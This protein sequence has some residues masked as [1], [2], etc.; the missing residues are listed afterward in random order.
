[1]LAQH[2]KLPA[3]IAD[4]F[5]IIFAEVR[6]RLEVRRQALRQP[7]QLDITLRFALEPTAGLDAVEVAINVK[8][9]KDGGMVSRLARLCWLLPRKAQEGKVKFV[10]EYIDH[11]HWIIFGHVVGQ[12][13]RQQR[14]LVTILAFD[15]ALHFA[16]VLMR[17]WLKFTEPRPFTRGYVF[18]QPGSTAVGRDSV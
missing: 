17:Y 4:R 15:K 5:A 8:L 7:H 16:S 10:H 12:E 3:H 2:D 13:F 14:T 9:E 11:P 6:D 1:L 18:T